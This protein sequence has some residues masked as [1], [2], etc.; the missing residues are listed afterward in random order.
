[1]RSDLFYHNA[2]SNVLRFEALYAL[3]RPDIAD[4]EST[5]VSVMSLLPLPGTSAA[6]REKI[7]HRLGFDAHPMNCFRQ[8]VL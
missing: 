8:S 4:G 3:P 1:M 6:R 5:Y 2:P 7:C